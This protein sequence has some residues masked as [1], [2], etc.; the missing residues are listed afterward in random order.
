MERTYTKR[1]VDRKATASREPSDIHPE[2]GTRVRFVATCVECGAEHELAR[3]PRGP[4]RCASCMEG[5]TARPA[6][7]PAPVTE[8]DA[9]FVCSG[10]GRHAW[11]PR[12]ALGTHAGGL[13]CV[14]CLRG[15]ERANPDRVD[16][17]AVL[18]RNSG[19]LRKRVARTP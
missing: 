19:V 4:F 1:G 13:L 5:S 9:E 3:A 11:A 15:V 10:C 14:D 12:S 6:A 16:G 17:G 7:P 2:H 8:T 18:D